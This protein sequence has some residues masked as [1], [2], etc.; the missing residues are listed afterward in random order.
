[1]LIKPVRKSGHALLFCFSMR[2]VMHGL[3]QLFGNHRY[4]RRLQGERFERNPQTLDILIGIALKVIAA[5]KRSVVEKPEHRVFRRHHPFLERLTITWQRLLALDDWGGA[6]VPFGNQAKLFVGVI[7]VR[8]HSA[9][10]AWEHTFLVVLSKHTV[11]SGSPAFNA[12]LAAA[13]RARR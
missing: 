12:H 3:L 8:V 1:L 11:A 6:S 5:S 10:V 4:R 13:E 7:A 2:T 9:A